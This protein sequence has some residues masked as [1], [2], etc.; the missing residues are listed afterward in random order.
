MTMHSAADIF[1]LSSFFVLL[2]HGTDGDARS[3]HPTFA[4]TQINQAAGHQA[5]RKKDRFCLEKA[6]CHCYMKTTEIVQVK[7]NK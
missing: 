6:G 4:K 2:V 5:E 1:Q 7:A 3:L